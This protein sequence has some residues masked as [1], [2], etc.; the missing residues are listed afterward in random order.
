MEYEGV[1]GS[2]LDPWEALGITEE[3]TFHGFTGV[4]TGDRRIDWILYNSGFEPLSASVMHYENEGHYPSDHFPV[5][6]TFR[7]IVQEQSRGPLR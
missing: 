2:L 4:A 6:A 5:E 3:G 1:S 7:G